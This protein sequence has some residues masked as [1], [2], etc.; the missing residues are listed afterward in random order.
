MGQC[1]A[2]L[3]MIIDFLPLISKGSP[4]PHRSQRCVNRTAPIF[5]R[6]STT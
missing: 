3:L 1:T 6:T 4:S 5:G 2:E